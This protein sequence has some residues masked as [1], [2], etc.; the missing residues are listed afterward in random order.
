MQGTA[1]AAAGSNGEVL[2]AVLDGPLLVG[3]GN[4]VLE[5]GGV[6]GV[7]GDGNLHAFLLHDGN[8][9]QHVVGAVALNGGALA[10]GEGLLTDDLQLAGGEVVV[11]LH[12]G[13]A[14][15]TADDIGSVLAQAVQ[16]NAQGGLA[17]LVGGAGDADGALSS[18]EAL[19]ASQEGKALGLV[20]QQHGA[21]VAV[22]QTNSALLGYGTGNGESLQAL[23]DGGGAV[24][25]VLQ[26]ALDSDGGAQGVGPH[27]VFKA[28]GL[29]ALDNSLHVDA[30]FQQHVAA[31]VQRFQAVGREASLDLGHT[32]LLTFKFSHS[33]LLLSY[34]S[35]G[36]IYLAAPSKRP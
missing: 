29:H 6:G 26:A 9:F 10:L 31:G 17:G 4:Q 30:L 34:S 18:G 36:S 24:G 8:A 12:I 32:A 20:T 35:R 23:A 33:C 27:G 3:A 11:G 25:G 15:D 28:D 21:Q 2:L 22:A 19:V 5:A 1:G 14:V 7:T 13:E 16:D